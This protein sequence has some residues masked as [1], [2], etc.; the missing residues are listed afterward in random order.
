MRKIIYVFLC[1]LCNPA[2]CGVFSTTGHEKANGL[3]IEVHYPENWIVKEGIRPHIVQRFTDQNGNY[4]QL[5]INPIGQVLSKEEWD[6]LIKNST[7]SDWVELLGSTYNILSMK[8]T[9]YEGLDG[10]M[11]KTELV[12]ER[13]GKTIYGL[14]IMHI[15]GYKDSWIMFGCM[16]G[17]LS[18]Q[19]AE[20]KF[21]AV[22][23]DFVRFGNGL[24]ILDKYSG[25]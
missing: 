15:L 24:V 13:A 20:Q 17:G 11:F 12:G 5:Q 6:E 3:D 19:V 25:V 2:V 10:V 22:E 1:L 8:H 16:A 14:G 9:K 23:S 21:E 4:C 18:K 7:K